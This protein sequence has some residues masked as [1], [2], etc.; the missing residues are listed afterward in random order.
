MRIC[1]QLTFSHDTTQGFAAGWQDSSEDQNTSHSP[2]FHSL[3]SESL[4][5]NPKHFSC[6][7]T[8]TISYPR[9]WL[10]WWIEWQHLHAGWGSARKWFQLAWFVL[11]YAKETQKRTL[12]ST[13]FCVLCS[14]QMY[15][16]I[17]PEG[18]RY[19]PENRKVISDSQA[20]ATKE[21]T[22]H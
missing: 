5:H 20:F 19:N 2:L 14:T 8:I 12:L 22:L 16:V 21:G 13:L 6:Y 15:L 10:S 17:F 1:C 9:S 11:R 7:W 4:F 3:C 18:T